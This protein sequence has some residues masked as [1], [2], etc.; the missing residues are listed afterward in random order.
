MLSAQTKKVKTKYGVILV[1]NGCGHTIY[2]DGMIVGHITSGSEKYVYF[3]K[4]GKNDIRERPVA[5]FKYRSSGASAKHW[6]RFALANHTV[7]EV[8]EALKDKINPKTGFPDP[9]STPY[10]WAES[11]GYV[12]YVIMKTRERAALRDGFQKSFGKI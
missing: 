11:L 12:P 5:R 3:Y 2:Q 7:A 1:N 8:H 10:G 9:S 6:V 4:H